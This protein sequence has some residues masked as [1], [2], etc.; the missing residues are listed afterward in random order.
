MN[1]DHGNCYNFDLPDECLN[2]DETRDVINAL[3]F[4]LR[5]TPLGKTFVLD[6][7]I[8]P[9][10]DSDM[11]WEEFVSTRAKFKRAEFPKEKAKYE[12]SEVIDF[13]REHF[14]EMLTL[15]RPGLRRIK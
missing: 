12:D 11:P 6:I 2:A 7:A 8:G 15:P 4:D 5:R 3:L 1:I 9:E 13:L 10:R 14:D